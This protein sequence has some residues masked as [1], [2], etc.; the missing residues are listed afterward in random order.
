MWQT[1]LLSRLIMVLCK[2]ITPLRRGIFVLPTWHAGGRFFVSWEVVVSLPL[3]VVSWI[4]ESLVLNV[5]KSVAGATT[6]V[7]AASFSQGR[8]LWWIGDGQV[9]CRWLLSASGCVMSF[10]HL[11]GVRNH[12]WPLPVGCSATVVFILGLHVWSLSIYIGTFFLQILSWSVSFSSAKETIAPALYSVLRIRTISCPS[13]LLQP[14]HW[15]PWVPF[16]IK[17]IFGQC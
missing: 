13:V 8:R 5:H 3:A 7:H 6:A 16:W 2:E 11:F 10:P 4:P 9:C 17:P 15:E 12:S 1:V 14:N